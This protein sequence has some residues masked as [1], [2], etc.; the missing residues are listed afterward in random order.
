MTAVQYI[1]KVLWRLLDTTEVR[2]G[3]GADGVREVVALLHA[4]EEQAPKE[5]E[6]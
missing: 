5:D 3:L 6:Q 2:Q 4:A 1:V